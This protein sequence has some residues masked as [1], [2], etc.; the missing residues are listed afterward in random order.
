MPLGALVRLSR[1][2]LLF[3]ITLCYN[4]PTCI[5]FSVS[6]S[7]CVT[8][9][10]LVEQMRVVIYVTDCQLNENFRMILEMMATATEQLKLVEYWLS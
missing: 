5:R 2:H 4:L 9:V 8:R 1:Y 6:F 7:V 10:G 3:R